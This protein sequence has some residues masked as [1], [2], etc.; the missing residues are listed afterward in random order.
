MNA[1]DHFPTAVDFVIRHEGGYT[2]DPRDPGGETKYGISKRAHPDIDITSLTREG[3]ERIYRRDYWDRLHLNRLPP[4]LAV[5]TLDAAV[6]LGPARAVKILQQSLGIFCKTSLA[7]DGVLGPATLA[8]SGD[9]TEFES[10]LAAKECILARTAFYARLAKRGSM[11]AFLR[12]W[13][14]RA[15]ALSEYLNQAF[16]VSPPRLQKKSPTEGLDRA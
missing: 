10:R 11:R 15:T 3:A 7:V 6:N 1:M 5:A 13:T 2:D 16:P 9:L 14:L 12:G 4:I 8:A